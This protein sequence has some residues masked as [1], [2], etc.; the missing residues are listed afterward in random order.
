VGAVGTVW[1][2]DLVGTP[3]ATCWSDSDLCDLRFEEN[4]ISAHHNGPAMYFPNSYWAP[5]TVLRF[6]RM[7]EYDSYVD[8]L[9]EDSFANDP[10]CWTK[11]NRCNDGGSTAWGGCSAW[12]RPNAF[13]SAPCW[14]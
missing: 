9:E 11:N 7:S 12:Q 13:Q 14:Y 2:A 5:S 1:I 3:E 6:N 8:V 4:S 10:R